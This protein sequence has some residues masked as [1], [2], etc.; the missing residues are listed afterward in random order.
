[1]A[2]EEAAGE[3]EAETR[4]NKGI[5]RGD[6][7]TEEDIVMKEEASVVNE[8]TIEVDEKLPNV[9]VIEGS[10]SNVEDEGKV[11]GEKRRKMLAGITIAS[12]V[13]GLVMLVVGSVLLAQYSIFL[14]FVTSRYTET[15]VFLLVM[16]IV[17]MVV[18]AIGDYLPPPPCPGLYAALNFHF[19][20]MTTFL[21]IMVAA[22]VMEVIASVTFFALNND[23]SVQAD[24]RLMLR[25]SLQTWMEGGHS[26]QDQF[27]TWNLIQVELQCCGLEGALDYSPNSPLPASCCAALRVTLAGT[28]PCRYH[29]RLVLSS[30]RHHVGSPPGLPLLTDTLLQPH[31]HRNRLF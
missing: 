15:A 17:I 30:H 11:E 31:Y 20:L 25:R 9:V 22:V 13:L 28:E 7:V 23:P 27:Q 18:S 10:T 29:A 2:G 3:A 26:E 1:M 14:D 8:D 24:T 12:I 21:V 5:E 19:C 16:G 6:T 4:E